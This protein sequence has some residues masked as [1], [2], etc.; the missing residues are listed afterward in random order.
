MP[1]LP[2]LKP[3][4][5]EDRFFSL[6]LNG[7][8]GLSGAILSGLTVFPPGQE[9]SCGLYYANMKNLN[10][11]SK[12]GMGIMLL[13][14]WSAGAGEPT[15]FQLAK[16]GNRFIG[17]QSKD[18]VVQIRSEKSVG[19]LAPKIWF[20]VYYDPTAALK[21]VEV[22]FGAGKML[23]V[24]RP[25]RLLPITGSDAPLDPAKLKVDSDQAIQIASKERLLEKLTLTASE[26][27]LQR[28]REE[29]QPVWKV[30]LWA[31]KLNRPSKSV[32]VGEV[33]IGAQDGKVLSSDWHINRVD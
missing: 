31:A 12:V 32:E 10:F 4:G 25:L 24:K 21:A 2:E 28:A 16:E 33:T 13:S 26:L 5:I 19:G 29:A 6:E 1:L 17:E 8:A 30:K 14:A 7:G 3:F 22:K 15:A 23:A 27:K 11:G 18:K 9:G 20:V